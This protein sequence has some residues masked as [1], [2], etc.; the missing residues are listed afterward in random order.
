MRKAMIVGLMGVLALVVLA[1][2][3]LAAEPKPSTPHVVIVGISE[4]ADKQINGRPH[5]EDDAK[6]LYDLF[7]SQ[8]HLGAE[9][10]QVKLL[11][12]K[13]DAARKSQPA[14]KK[15]ILDA[16]A[17][18]KEAKSDDLV[19]FAYIGQ[20]ASLGE[21]GDR[22]CYFTSDSTLKDRADTAVAAASIGDEFNKVKS[23][24]VV[25]LLD[26]NFKGFTTQENIPAATLGSPPY[27]EFL[28]DDGTEDHAPLP[29]R[30][31]YVATDG[32][33]PSLDLD[34]HGVFTTVVLDALKGQADKEGKEADGVIVVDELT[35]HVS[36][37]LPELCRQHG[38]T[39]EQKEQVPL[40]MGGRINH[41]AITRNPAVADKVQQQLEKLEQLLKDKKI[42]E[43]VAD[44]G[45]ELLRRMPKLQAQRDLRK[46]FQELV[47]GTLTPEKFQE[48]YDSIIA[49]TKLSAEE[50]KE[51]ATSVM[52]AVRSINARYVKKTEPAEL[53][54]WAIR[55][56]YKRLEE[57]LPEDVVEKLGQIK[58]LKESELEEL[59]STIRTRLGKREDLD[60]HK[61]VDIALQRMMSHLDP[62]TTYI[63]KESKEGAD[64]DLQGMF[65]GIGIQIRK[66]AARDM[67]QVVT[68]IKGSPAHKK[69][70]QAGDIV[71]KIIRE[72]DS[73]GKPLTPPEEIS[74]KGLPL[75][76]AVKKILGEKGTKVK[77]VI[78]REG[79]AK[80]L[81]MEV[82]RD[83]VDVETVL[84]YRRKENGEWN[85]WVDE[86]NRIA[87]IRL[88]TFGRKTY[89]NLTDVMK[90]LKKDGLKGLILDLRF[91]P[92][93]L[94]TSAV[95]ISDLF[96]DD[97]LIVTVRPRV[98]KPEPY[99]GRSEGSYLGFPMVCLVNGGSASASE[100]VSACLQDQGRAIIVGERS[101]GKGS[102]QNIMPFEGGDLKMTIATFWR[103]SD[104]NLNKSSTKGTD[105]EDWGVRPN[106]GFQVTLTSKEREDLF[107]H[108][109]NTE[110]IQRPDKFTEGL[111]KLEE[112]KDGQMD[113]GLEYLREQLKRTGQSAGKG[114]E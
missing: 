102:V 62:Y 38:K 25:V 10:A 30:A 100:I 91:N 103:P 47:G 79:E 94:L 51:F 107:D 39:R 29:G 1:R 104:K 40:I 72:E 78:E 68:P 34:K 48:T 87:Y 52:K 22:R 69:G 108:Q 49:R 70:I 82:V 105:D 76:D 101:Y 23:T 109:R 8:D 84:G 64:K 33:T 71:T 93:G 112:F 98:G 58:D 43:K 31:I 80:A 113:R 7:T 27:K 74:T 4:F 55:G 35:E 111:K 50:A 92:G 65:T 24:R 77:L 13:P 11:L 19:V 26:V 89:E 60:N 67:L 97:G 2:P 90:S 32:L 96:I 44:E 106:K 61:D 63:D 12:G 81:E 86:A 6:A 73:H 5:A 56:L 41:F 54:N 83:R 66:D 57:K 95:D 53:V 42:V 15:N 28:G 37:E 99:F 88:T 3:S 45:R 110:I 14:T 46:A 36:K 18:L 16:V 114:S 9:P 17:W 75:S 85:Y 21:R 20:G 59:L